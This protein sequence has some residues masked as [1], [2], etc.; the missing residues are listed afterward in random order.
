MEFQGVNWPYLNLSAQ[1]DSKGRGADVKNGMQQDRRWLLCS[2][3]TSWSHTSVTHIC[4]ALAF[5]G[6]ILEQ[7]FSVSFL[8]YA[9][10]TKLQAFLGMEYLDQS[11]QV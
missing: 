5:F 6:L 3:Q 9:P 10:L 7:L 1:Q 4:F 2:G 11:S 8:L